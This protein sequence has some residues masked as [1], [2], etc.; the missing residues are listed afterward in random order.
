MNRAYP[1]RINWENEPSIST[2]INDVNLNKMDNAIYIIDGRV[3]EFDTTKAN[4]SDLLASL[5][6]VTYNS[7]TGVFV[8][9]YNNGN[10]LNVDLNVEKIP[11]SFS[12]SPQGI[13]TMETSDGTQYTCDVSTLIKIYDFIDSSEINFTVT[14]DPQTGDKSVTAEIVNGSITDAKLQPQYLAD[15]TAQAQAADASAQ[16]ASTSAGNAATSA[17]DSEAWAAGTRNGQAVPSTDPA[18]E[19]NAKYW[20]QQ[21]A[22]IVGITIATT[23]TPGIVMPD[24]DTISVSGTGLIKFEGITDAEYSA[25]QTLLS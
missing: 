16:S 22:A 5:R 6:S 1:S 13:I 23:T 25:I 4:Q 20:A 14:V 8:F 17:T 7:T 9:T 3:V 11:V 24:G 19:N 12:M 15:I 18:Y 21:A 10:T 2:P